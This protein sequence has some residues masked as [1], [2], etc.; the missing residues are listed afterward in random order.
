MAL[1]SLDRANFLSRAMADAQAYRLKDAKDARAFLDRELEIFAHENRL[2]AV[3]A[4]ALKDSVADAI[5][6]G[7]E[8]L[9]DRLRHLALE[10]LAK[11]FRH[12][13]FK[14]MVRAVGKAASA[15]L[16][17]DGWLNIR[18]MGQ[19][20]IE[21]CY[22]HSDWNVYD[23]MRMELPSN[24]VPERGIAEAL[25]A[26]LA[27]ELEV[28]RHPETGALKIVLPPD[29]GRHEYAAFRFPK[30]APGVVALSFGTGTVGAFLSHYTQYRKEGDR[31]APL[32]PKPEFPSFGP[33]TIEYRAFEALTR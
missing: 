25:H 24:A 20:L 27:L 18:G 15:A 13:S 6:T 16:D 2:S 1:S 14:E 22:A 8:A 21:L 29:S 17:G 5:L 7:G 32:E 9:Q 26:S 23:A 28:H 19:A 10:S 33:E 11:H 30:S 31:W 4:L 12:A 3:D